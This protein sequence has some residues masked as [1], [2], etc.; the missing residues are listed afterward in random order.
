LELERSNAL[1]QYAA[2]GLA[3]SSMGVQ[4]GEQAV[5][6][7]AFDIASFDA[8]QFLTKARDEFGTA[9]QAKLDKLNSDYRLAQMA[10][11]FNYDTQ[12]SEQ[13]Y[14][15]NRALNE[16]QFGFNMTLEGQRLAS[17]KAIN[18]QRFGFDTKLNDQKIAGELKVGEQKFGFDQK[19]TDQQIAGDIKVNESK[20]ALNMVEQKDQ[21]AFT[22]AE[23]AETR[24]HEL[25]KID[26][27]VAAQ[28]KGQI[29]VVNA[30]LEGN[31]RRDYNTAQ[32]SAIA[33]YTTNINTIRTNPELSEDQRKEAEL[34]AY[35][36]L[37][38]RIKY[39]S[40]LYSS[41]AK[42]EGAVDLTP[43]A[44]VTPPLPEAPKPKA[45]EAP[46]KPEPKLWPALDD[47]GRPK[48]RPTPADYERTKGGGQA[49]RGRD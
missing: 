21:Q 9:S 32:E 11:Q 3:N 35:A 4:A 31:L 22:A 25:A 23:S 49:D 38:V 44:P 8:N 24:I 14:T 37:E 2:K 48:P 10:A 7:K 47:L 42:V 1:Q 34:G 20:H 13:S 45:P 17:E 43:F 15:Q 46:V 33:E 41:A 19:I 26:A 30:Q 18:E 27:E 12:L 36:D 16:Q 28:V 40:G 39:N 29:D 5:V 6:A